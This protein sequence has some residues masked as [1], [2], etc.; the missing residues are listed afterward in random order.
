MKES[1]ENNAQEKEAG[2]R[3]V[4]ID[5]TPEQFERVKKLADSNGLSFSAQVRCILQGVATPQFVS[6]I[7]SIAD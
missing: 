2:K 3:R 4:T 6:S 1:H 7:S 5:L